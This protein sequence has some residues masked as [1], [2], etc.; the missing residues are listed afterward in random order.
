VTAVQVSLTQPISGQ[1]GESA[2][3]RVLASGLVD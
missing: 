1:H 2:A 3:D